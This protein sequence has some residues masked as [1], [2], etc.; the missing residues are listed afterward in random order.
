M[1]YEQPTLP[2]YNNLGWLFNSIDYQILTKSDGWYQDATKRATEFQEGIN[3]GMTYAAIAV[4]YDNVTKYRDYVVSARA[5]GLKIWHRSHWNAWQGDNGVGNI[6]T[7]TSLTRSGS[8]AT[9]VT[10]TPHGL[11]TG[12][13]VSING[14]DQIEYRGEFV[15]TV[16]DSTTF[17]YQIT[18]IPVSPATG[19]IGWRFGRATYIRKTKQF[20][21][22]NNDLFESGD[23]FGMCVEADQADQSNL[24]FKTPGTTSFDTTIYNQFQKNQVL[25]AN[26]AFASAGITGVYTWG[27]SHQLANLNLNGQVLNSGNSG[28]PSGLGD[29][30]ITTYFGGILCFD[31]YVSDAITDPATYA[32]AYNDDL[33]AIHAAFPNAQLFIGEW[34]YHTVSLPSEQNQKDVYEAVIDV[35]LTKNYVIGVNFWN[36]MGQ[37]QSSLWNDAS[38]SIVPGGRPATT[39]V[40]RAFTTLNPFLVPPSPPEPEPEPEPPVIIIP[41][42]AVSAPKHQIIVKDKDQNIIGEISDWFDLK[43]SDQINNYGK[44]S[45]AIPIDSDDATKLISPRRYEIVITQSGIPVW[46]GEQVTPDVTVVADSP[47]LITV[48]CYTY[49]EMLNA[50]YTPEYVRYDQIDQAEILKALVVA[51]QA[52]TDGDFGFTFA[53]ITHTKLRDREYKTDNIMESFINMSNVIDGVDFWIDENKI[54]HFG[55]P[56]RG[57]DKSNQFSFEYKVNI[58]EIKI[59]DDFSSPANTAYAIGTEPDGVTP[60]IIPF[61]D[62]SA[63]SV[64]KLREQTISAID[65]I[66]EDTLEGKAEDLVN[67]NK[68][69]KRTVRITQL[70]NTTPSLTQLQIGDSITVVFKKG[71]YDINS[72][73]RVLGYECNI[74]EVGETRVTWILADYQSL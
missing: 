44:A 16:I 55:T 51:S 19:N 73:F 1:A 48:N 64:Y 74:G 67:T 3:K 72:A 29:S 31:H 30:D 69:Q 33:E 8:V 23:I 17:T 6:A 9:C 54:I 35:L 37:A 41:T 70:P 57:V 18:G 34:G 24:T 40:L 36:H 53:P 65:I 56:K 26:N 20:I 45:F 59:T 66:E 15:V 11:I 2:T 13:T 63:R 50:R 47:N 38:G 28:N 61:A 7:P 71:R 42:V 46:S 14:V 52:K 5:K 32:S 39:E 62:S 21:T 58:E 25:E 43:F 12:D 27:I 60:L 4:P 22:D 49:L 10:N 68:S